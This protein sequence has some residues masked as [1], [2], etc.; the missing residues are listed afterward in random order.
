MRDTP[1]GGSGNIIV[2]CGE[3]HR[4]GRLDV[5]EADAMV[6]TLNHRNNPLEN[7]AAAENCE[8]SL[9]LVMNGGEVLK[10]MLNKQAARQC[11]TARLAVR[12]KCSEQ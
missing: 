2:L 1:S 3:R 6:D 9:G 11:R 4:Y 8:G 10:N 7:V 5:I 12:N